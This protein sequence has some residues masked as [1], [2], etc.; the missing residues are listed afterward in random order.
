MSKILLIL[1]SFL[2]LCLQAPYLWSAWNSSRL[3]QWDW[4]FFIL[5]AVSVFWAIRGEKKFK[6]DFYA[7]FALIPMLPFALGTGFHHI[8][9]LSTACAVGSVFCTVWLCCSWSFA[10]RVLPCAVILLMGT[11]SSSY[12]FSL[13]CMCPVWMAWMIKTALALLCF[14]W[15]FCNQYFKLEIRVGSLCFVTAL[16]GSTLLLLHTEDLYYKGKSFVPEFP[17][18][19]EGYLGRR[20]QSDPE[21]KRFF[22]TSTVRQYRYTGDKR[23]ISV[24]AV[25]CGSNIHEIHPAGHCLRTTLWTI[26]SEKT[27]HLKDHFA[28]TEIDARKGNS[29]FLVWVWYSNEEF[30]TPSFLGFRRHFRKGGRYFTCQ[31]STSVKKS[32]EESRKVLSG[33]IETL[34]KRRVNP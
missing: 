34:K 6:Y 5:A 20:V 30:S 32:P 27:L 28:V 4:I 8:H 22:A 15:I 16:L 18:R 31:I 13:L 29:H 2:P 1:V 14:F 21:T 3:D 24:L 12:Q 26:H 25:Q 17:L 33:F 10:Y 9:A 23:D 11:P 19:M 7:L